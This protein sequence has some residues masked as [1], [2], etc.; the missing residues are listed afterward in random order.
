MNSGNKIILVIGIARSG[1]TWLGKIFD[2]HPDVI[3]KH[4]PDSVIKLTKV[5]LFPELSDSRLYE[6]CINGYLRKLAG[7]NAASICTKLPIFKKSYLN[8]FAYGLL[9]VNSMI[10]KLALRY[11]SFNVPILQPYQYDPSR[12]WLVWKS[13]ESMSRLGVIRKASDNLKIVF[14]IRHPCGFVASLMQGKKYGYMPTVGNVDIDVP[15]WERRLKC[16]V[17]KRHNLTLS[18]VMRMSQVEELAW[19][20]M[21]DNDQALEDLDGARDTYSVIYD[22]LCSDPLSEAMKIFEFCCLPWSSTTEKFLKASTSR[23]DSHYFSVFKNPKVAANKWKDTLSKEQIR[24]IWEIVSQ[25]R[26]AEFFCNN[27]KID[28]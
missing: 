22:K 3:Y 26:T 10:A 27:F 25:S 20:W 6:K 18:S 1:T 12:H 14:L 13:I 23:N 28:L 11:L 21:V 15:L 8:G 4:E 16:N 7:M 2:S 5:P 17:S 9:K 19:R 24:T